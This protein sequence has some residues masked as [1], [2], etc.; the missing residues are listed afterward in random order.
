MKSTPWLLLTVCALLI[1]P[2]A[3]N[4]SKDQNKALALSEKDGW[5]LI[6][7]EGF[8]MA[9]PEGWDLN[10]SGAMSTAFILVKPIDSALSD[11]RQNISYIRQELGSQEMSLEEYTNLSLKQ[12]ESLIT[13]GVVSTVDK[14][15][16][17]H[18]IIY[19]SE[20][21]RYSLSFLQ[22]Y[23]ITEGVAH[24]LTFSCQQDQFDAATPLAKQ[25]F[26]SFELK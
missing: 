10:E 15:A 16:E 22:R 25:T 19:S 24:I 14:T 6:D 21:G 12:I 8:S 20:Q 7:R 9:Y 23:W 5:E 2:A 13:D 1:L 17:Y 4:E 11:F 18:Q 3:C 26:D